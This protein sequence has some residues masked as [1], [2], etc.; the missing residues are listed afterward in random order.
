MMPADNVNLP[1]PRNLSWLCQPVQAQFCR[2]DD[3]TLI[4]LVLDTPEHRC[5]TWWAPAMFER[6]ARRML[7]EIG[8]APDGLVLADLSDPVPPPPPEPGP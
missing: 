3:G 8:A 1:P 6:V 5:I 4:G 2:S 7:A